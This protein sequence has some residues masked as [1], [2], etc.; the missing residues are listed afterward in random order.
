VREALGDRKARVFATIETV[1]LPHLLRIPGEVILKLAQIEVVMAPRST[2]RLA[3]TV[4]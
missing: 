4:I 3:G 2:A 1:R